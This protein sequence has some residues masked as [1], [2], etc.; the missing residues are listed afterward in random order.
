MKGNEA[1][2]EG[3]RKDLGLGGR[4]CGR[5]LKVEVWRVSREQKDVSGMA[6]TDAL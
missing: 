5:S 6:A 4:D 1:I 2:E 3:S